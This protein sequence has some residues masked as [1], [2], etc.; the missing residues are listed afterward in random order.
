MSEQKTYDRF[1]T[2]KDIPAEVPTY[3][4]YYASY[5]DM[6]GDNGGIDWRELVKNVKECPAREKHE[7][8]LRVDGVDRE[9]SFAEFFWRLGIPTKE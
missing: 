8:V 2:V 4:V 7:I 3:A 5:W 9:F 6:T 1:L